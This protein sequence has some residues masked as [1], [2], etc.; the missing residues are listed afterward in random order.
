MANDNNQT[1]NRNTL[2]DAALS[3]AA[4]GW[5]VLPIHTIKDGKCTCS[6]GSECSS[7]GKHPHLPNGVS[8]ATTDNNA[9]IQWWTQWPDA[10]VAIATGEKSFDA[11]DVD[12]K[13]DG[14]STVEELEAEY[15][16]L[17]DTLCQIT[18]SGGR[19]YFFKY[20]AEI[21]NTVRFSDGL[22]TRSDGGYVIVPPS[23]HYSGGTYQW[24]CGRA[25][26][27]L[28]LAEMPEWLIR[29]IGNSD[30]KKTSNSIEEEIAEGGRNDAL[31]SIGC[32]M[33][34]KGLHIE[35]IGPA[36][37]KVNERRCKPPLS[38]HEV[39]TIIKSVEKYEQ[40][41]ITGNRLPA[42]GNPEIDA[43]NQNVQSVAKEAWDAL[44]TAN[45]PPRFFKQDG[46]LVHVMEDEGVH[47]LRELDEQRLR[48][49]L[50]RIANWFVKTGDDR[51]PARPPAFVIEDMLADPNPPLPKLTKLIECPIFAP[52][53]ILHSAPGYSESTRCY[54]SLSNG[55][56]IP[57]VSASPS[58]EEVLKARQLVQNLFCDFPFVSEA[59]RVMAFSLFILPFAR[60]LIS[61]PVPIYLIEAPANG[62]GKTL[63]AN[64]TA[65]S[66]LG[67]EIP[68]MSGTKSDEEFRKR[69]T[70]ILS[71]SPSLVL[72]DNLSGLLD[73]NQLAVAITSMVWEDRI[74]GATKTVRL[75]A[76]CAW[77][78]TANN[79]ELSTELTRR[80]VRIRM[81]AKMDRP[82]NRDPSSFKHSNII[83]FARENRG[84]LIWAALTII[85]NWLA[86]DSPSAVGVKPIG[87][88]EAY[89]YTIG[90]ILQ[91]AGI[92]GFLDNKEEF[93]D[94]SDS[95]TDT[96]RS[97]VAAWWQEFQDREVGVAQL[98]PLVDKYEIPLDLGNSGSD[99]SQK[100]KFGRLLASLR[101]RQVGDYRIC[102]GGSKDRAK[103]YRLLQVAESPV[104]IAVETDQS[105]EEVEPN[106]APENPSSEMQHWH[107]YFEQADKVEPSSKLNPTEE[108]TRNIA[109]Y[110]WL[111]AMA[112]MVEQ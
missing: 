31:F 17:P 21:K 92:N 4:E 61:G 103:Q 16:I 62:T 9:I 100:T 52:T 8:G 71:R 45:L 76:R 96:F 104:A 37:Q 50:A 25:P 7:A 73:S 22:D 57:N 112:D 20:S 56:N 11:L 32:S 19:Q 89:C 43:R 110:T 36:L 29:I 105:P 30:N 95:E 46:R 70:A 58:P 68:A 10:N 55:L 64:I 66:A 15:G 99:K 53:G 87:S 101:D 108:P 2:L 82:W 42:N 80:T 5:P 47:S 3:Y 75:P 1:L 18:G 111:D 12:I 38:Q 107:D 84:E 94:A 72:M 13:G 33:Q 102:A 106:P 91:C 34:A 83:K 51:V 97:L 109:D 60:E 85:Q 6:K 74:L 81:D 67:R 24:E 90:G 27:D 49:F 26:S 79:L 54:L 39:E 23:R 88:F 86:N 77:I 69:I 98:Y 41:P 48:Y 14:K 93:Y 44:T 78:I 65:F 28:P 40:K 35:E 59:E 63:L